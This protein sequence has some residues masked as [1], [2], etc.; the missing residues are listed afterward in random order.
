VLGNVISA[1]GRVGP[2]AHV[3]YRD[4]KLTRILK[5]SL[6]GNHKTL[7]IACISKSPSNESETKSTLRYANRA[8]NIRNHAKINVDP[9]YEV[10]QQLRSRVAALAAELLRMR[11]RGFDDDDDEHNP[12]SID[13]LKDLVDRTDQ[14]RREKNYPTR[15]KN[16][17]AQVKINQRPTS[18]PMISSQG[19]SLKRNVSVSWHEGPSELFHDKSEHD[20]HP[21]DEHDDHPDDNSAEDPE[22]AKNIESYDFA[23][24]TLRQSLESKNQRQS[25]YEGDTHQLDKWENGAIE[26]SPIQRSRNVSL[27]PERAPELKKIR[28]IDELYD[29]LNDHTHMNE[30]GEIVDDEGTVISQV[31]NSHVIKLD[32]AISQNERLL[33]EMEACHEIFEGSRSDNNENLAEIETELQLSRNEKEGLEKVKEDLDGDFENSKGLMK[34]LAVKD[35][36]ISELSEERDDLIQLN[37]NTHENLKSIQD[38]QNS[39]VVMKKQR[40]DLTNITSRPRSRGRDPPSLPILEA[41]SIETFID[42]AIDT[43]SRVYREGLPLT[44]EN[45]HELRATRSAKTNPMSNQ[46][47]HMTGFDLVIDQSEAD[48]HMPRSRLTTDEAGDKLASDVPTD[49]RRQKS[50]RHALA[51]SR[52]NKSNENI[53]RILETSLNTS[54]HSKISL[55]ETPGFGPN[56]FTEP[57]K[58]G[59]TVRE[60]RN[61]IEKNRT[62]FATRPDVAEAL[63]K[64]EKITRRSLYSG[65]VSPT[66]E[67]ASVYRRQLSKKDDQ[68]VSTLASP[69]SVFDVV[70]ESMAS[71]KMHS[72]TNVSLAGKTKKNYESETEEPVWCGAES[73]VNTIREIFGLKNPVLRQWDA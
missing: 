9:Q 29:Y 50:N 30:E 25:F 73:I 52:H 37:E 14:P 12:F 56:H 11:N 18:S 35:A 2:K 57:Y 43:S 68:T 66:E 22:L 53:P 20:G 62:S 8:K 47:G 5:G 65:R 59:R 17:H 60:I 69:R 28:N 54:H 40:S 55:L 23:L 46:T 31:V 15:R 27:S 36:K 63:L 7:M 3:P 71:S 41:S 10:V 33:K 48:A 16:S 49:G 19:V 44:P 58:R 26:D 45:M 13:F 39:I 64:M 24:A 51:N 1:L 4:S 70:E 34:A 32:D 21:D 61:E 38:L 72:G 6:G 42:T 67:V